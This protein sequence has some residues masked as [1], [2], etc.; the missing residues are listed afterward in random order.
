MVF[1]PRAIELLHQLHG[2]APDGTQQ[3][4]PETPPGYL[5]WPALGMSTVAGL[6]TVLGAFIVLVM[7]KEPSPSWMAGSLSL[8]A[9]VMIT[10]SVMELMPHDDHEASIM[11]QFAAFAAGTVFYFLIS[12]F[13]PDPHAVEEEG[14]SQK[15][16]VEKP[17]ED[18]AENDY[19][20][21]RRVASPKPGGGAS[22]AD[23]LEKDGASTKKAKRLSWVLFIVLTAHNFP[24]G[25]AVA[26]SAMSSPRLGIRLMIAIGLH[27]I[28]EGVTIA[29]TTLKA[30]G[31]KP[32]A[33][34]MAFLSGLTEPLGALCALLIL[35]PYLTEQLLTILLCFVAGVMCTVAV[36]ELLPEACRESCYLEAGC[37][38]VLGAMIMVGTHEL[39]AA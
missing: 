8:A 34:F 5:F 24:E 15:L 6:S 19:Y 26:I 18:P 21:C 28:P 1:G 30:T 14:E 4:L 22:E 10:V 7:D 20:C 23:D 11:D 13:L 25:L 3:A 12:C 33:V 17:N 35:W 27:N 36:L 38:F 29:V 37:G 32:Q 9:G 16:W 2:I 31:S 39:G